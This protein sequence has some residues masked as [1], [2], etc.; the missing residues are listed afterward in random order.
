[1]CAV[2]SLPYTGSSVEENVSVLGRPDQRLGPNRARRRHGARF[3]SRNV[4]AVARS[5]R[6]YVGPLAREAVIDGH[7]AAIDE[8]RILRVRGRF[9]VFFDVHRMPIVE[10]DLS[11]HTAALNASRTRIL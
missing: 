9:A 4:S 7:F 8:I 6:R 1:M 11:V 2:G 3:G 10:G 5:R